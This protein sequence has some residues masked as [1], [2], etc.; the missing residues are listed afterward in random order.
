[1]SSSQLI[2]SEGIDFGDPR[3][4]RLWMMLGCKIA[5]VQ[6]TLYSMKEVVCD[7]IVYRMT[8]NVVGH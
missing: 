6:N 2:A 5:S 1:M 7:L 8:V 4:W 3:N